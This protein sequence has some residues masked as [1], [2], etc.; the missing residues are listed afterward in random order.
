MRSELVPRR[1]PRV[2]LWRRGA[3]L[4]IDFVVVTVISS[5]F[6]MNAIAQAFLFIVAWLGMRVALVARNQGQ[7][8]GRWAFDMKV[9]DLRWGSTPALQEL[10]QREGL[11]AVGAV[12]MLFGLLNLSPA[13]PWSILLFIP[14]GID[15]ALAIMDE[16]KR[17]AFHDQLSRTVIVPTRRGYSLDLKLKSLW[18]LAQRRLKQR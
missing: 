16:E 15:C 3:A 17:Q 6:S 18:A 4:A 14:L 9:V 7:S 5:L 1:Y 2:P 12:L 8:L 13:S 10:T 11:M